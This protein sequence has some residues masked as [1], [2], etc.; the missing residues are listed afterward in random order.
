MIVWLLAFVALGAAATAVAWPVYSRA[1]TRE[2]RDVNVDRY[3]AWRGRAGTRS[4]GR[5]PLDDLRDARD[6][7]S[8]AVAAALAIA[9]IGCLIAFFATG[10]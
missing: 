2:A 4:P 6:R 5:S 9:A 3:L 10:G 7:R 1:R 8:L